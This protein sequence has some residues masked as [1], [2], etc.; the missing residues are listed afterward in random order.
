MRYRDLLKI[1]QNMNEAH[2]NDNVT[3]KIGDNFYRNVKLGTND[4]NE[5]NDVLDQGAIYLEVM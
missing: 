4:G 2:L 3:I 1:I 5:H